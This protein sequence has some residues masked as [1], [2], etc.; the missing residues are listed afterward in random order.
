MNLNV[1]GV[2]PW[3]GKQIRAQISTD[4]RQGGASERQWDGIQ[5]MWDLLA[6]PATSLPLTCCVALGQSL[7]AP[8]SFSTI[9]TFRNLLRKV[10][11]LLRKW[12]TSREKVFVNISVVWRRSPICL[13]FQSIPSKEK[14]SFSGRSTSSFS[15]GTGGPYLCAVPGA[16][17]Q[18]SSSRPLG[19]GFIT[20]QLIAGMARNL[21]CSK[22]VTEAL[23]AW[24]VNKQPNTV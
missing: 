12:S 13:S 15:W 17:G 5:E 10:R 18:R 7:W 23:A 14:Y 8:I 19:A 16:L 21:C 2:H 11:N 3:E 1:S 24:E 9:C 22:A 6:W 4:Q 20:V